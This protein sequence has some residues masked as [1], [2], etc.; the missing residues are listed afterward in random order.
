[1]ISAIRASVV[2][3][4]YVKHSCTCFVCCQ[5]FC[6]KGLC[7][8][9]VVYQNIAVHVLSAARISGIR[10]ISGSFS[11]IF[12]N[13][14][15]LWWVDTNAEIEVPSA[16]NPE[17]S[18]VFLFQAWSSPIYKTATSVVFLLYLFLSPDPRP[19][20]WCEQ[21]IRLLLVIWWITFHPDM[22]SAVD[23]AADMKKQSVMTQAC[24]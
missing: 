22:P 23:F 12:S 5:D 21:R 19:T 14:L 16:W 11:F 6:L 1:M 2:S 3:L 7:C 15:P 9:P 4:Q 20:Q 18:S 13:T 8:K 24:V 17:L 10:I